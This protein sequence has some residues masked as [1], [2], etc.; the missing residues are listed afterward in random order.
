MLFRSLSPAVDGENGCWLTVDGGDDDALRWFNQFNPCLVYADFE[1]DNS[2]TCLN[3]PIVFYNNSVGICGSEIYSW[4]FGDG[5]SPAAAEGAG[6]HEVIYGSSGIKYISLMVSGLIVDTAR[7]SI[8][9]IQIDTSLSIN[10]NSLTANETEGSYQWIDCQ[11]LL[12]I[13]GETNQVFTATTNGLYA[14]I[15]TK[16]GCEDTSGCY[17]LV[18]TDIADNNFEYNPVVFPNPTSGELNIDLQQFYN[19]ISIVVKNSTGQLI[20]TNQ[21]RSTRKVTLNINGDSGIYFVGIMVNKRKS[22]TLKVLKNQ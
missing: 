7:Q 4:D 19:T 15:I 10:G 2:E 13:P 11:T 8:E 3:E 16:I 21:Y 9:I 5:A 6:P 14:V 20:S 18:L 17:N 22:I 1:V 12:P